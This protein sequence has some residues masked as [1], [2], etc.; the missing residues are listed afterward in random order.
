MIVTISAVFWN[1]SC[2]V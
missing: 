1:A 2:L